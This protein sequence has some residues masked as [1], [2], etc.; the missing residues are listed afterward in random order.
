MIG[1]ANLYGALL[2]FNIGRPGAASFNL[3]LAIW[4]AYYIEVNR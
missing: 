3:L 2:L 1:C 4:M